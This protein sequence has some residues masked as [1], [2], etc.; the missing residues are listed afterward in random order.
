M[1]ILYSSCFLRR[2][3]KLP[4]SVKSAAERRE[5]LFRRD[6]HHPLLH[7]HKLKGRLSGLWAFSVDDTYRIIFEFVNEDVVLFQS[8]GNHSVYD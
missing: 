4:A 1:K 5:A 3:K 6:D 8:I 7:T 2:Y